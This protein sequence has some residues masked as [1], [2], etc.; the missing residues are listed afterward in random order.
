[1]NILAIDPGITRSNHCGWAIISE[2]GELI[3]SGN[4]TFKKTGTDRDLN[5]VNF[6]DKLCKK[7]F[8]HFGF[9][10][11]YGPNRKTL[12][13]TSNF[14]GIYKAVMLMNDKVEVGG[15]APAHIKKV[16]TGDGRASKD[17]INDLVCSKYGI[18]N[19]QKDEADAIAI[20]YTCLY[21][22]REN[23]DKIK[24]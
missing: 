7:E 1:M 3:K 10:K 2:D 21:H 20:T 17:D 19:V 9:E 4:K 16:F 14:L 5:A 11:P 22:W 13:S 24:T 18:D 6:F 8:T 12:R 15:F 23:N